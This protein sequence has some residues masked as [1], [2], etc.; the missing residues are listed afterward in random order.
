MA[1]HQDYPCGLSSVVKTAV[2]VPGYSEFFVRL[3]DVRLSKLWNRM[4]NESLYE[5]NHKPSQGFL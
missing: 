5:V 3:C 1:D 2:R 4:W